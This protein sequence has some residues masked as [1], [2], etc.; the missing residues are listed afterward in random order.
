MNNLIEFIQKES[1]NSRERVKIEIIILLHKAN[2]PLT[3]NFWINSNFYAFP[4]NSPKDL[5][6][7]EYR[8]KPI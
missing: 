5:V 7:T 1:L 6:R 3:K 8:Q 4:I 2:E